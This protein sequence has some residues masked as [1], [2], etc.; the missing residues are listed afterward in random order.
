MQMVEMLLADQTAKLEGTFSG[1]SDEKDTEI[2]TDLRSL[3]RYFAIQT[4]QAL[5]DW[6]QETLGTG[7][8]SDY[9]KSETLPSKQPAS[10]SRRFHILRG[11]RWRV[12]TVWSTEAI[13]ACCLG[14]HT[15]QQS[16]VL[17]NATVNYIALNR[18][19]AR[20][21][22]RIGTE[23]SE[24]HYQD[25]DVNENFCR[26]RAHGLAVAWIEK[27][28]LDCQDR[29]GIYWN[30]WTN[31]ADTHGIQGLRVFTEIKLGSP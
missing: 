25:F 14:D 9:T 21:M 30:R 28:L 18:L 27:E 31:I 22:D 23:I 3:C 16:H 12:S 10:L 29:P 8:M 6:F 5:I 11:T 13:V 7:T 20:E 17:R 19:L 4:V 2:I 1:T 15:D 24:Y 26:L